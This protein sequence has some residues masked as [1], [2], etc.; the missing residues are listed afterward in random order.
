[1]NIVNFNINLKIQI[2]EK[3][4]LCLINCIVDYPLKRWLGINLIDFKADRNLRWLLP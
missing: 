3:Y 2:G 4:S 1:M